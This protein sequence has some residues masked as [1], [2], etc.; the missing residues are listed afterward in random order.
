MTALAA[1]AP[2][3]FASAF[4]YLARGTGAVSLLLFTGVMVLGLLGSLRVSAGPK[5]PRFALDTM[6]RDVSLLAVAL[7]VLHILT[8]VLDGYAPIALTDAVIPFV[9]TYRPLWLGLGALALDIM[10]ALVITSLVRRRLGYQGWRAV[11]W[12][13]YASWPVAV[14]HGLGT[15]T[16]SNQWWMLALTAA[17]VAA[18][19]VALALRIARSDV[20]GPQ[21]TGALAAT[22]TVVLG[23][24]VFT[25]VGPLQRG[26]ARRAGTP[27]TLLGA[28]RPARARGTRV[29]VASQGIPFSAQVT[30]TLAQR[31]HPGGQVLDLDLA[32][33]GGA[34]GRLRVRM[35]GQPLS[36]GGLSMTGSQVDLV[37]AGLPGVMAGRIVSLQGQRFVARLSS[38]TGGRLNLGADL[39]IPGSGQAVTGA[40]RVTAAGSGG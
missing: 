36:G 13:S 39:Q 6:H 7:L 10:L 27:M 4:W 34:S 11:H 2:S 30:G 33:S 40:L 8:S 23:A 9:G 14:L 18:V 16:D 1:V 12:L 20:A 3:A 21:R 5:W 28:V 26:W 32:V 35:A 22:A 19:A 29:A 24:A 17:C 37:V 38:P 25:L 15:G 31:S